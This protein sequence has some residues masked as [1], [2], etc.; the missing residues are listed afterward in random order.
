MQRII[1]FYATQVKL[2]WEWRGGPVALV[3][4]LVLVLVVAT[5]SFVI[6]AWL[7]PGMFVDSLSASVLAVILISLFNSLIRPVVLALI[8]P[9]SLILT[10]IAVLVLQVLAFLFAAWLLPGVHFTGTVAAL[11]A[12]FVYAIVNTV[13][14]A[15]LGVD[16]GGSYFGYLVQA[17]RRKGAAPPSDQPGVV[18]F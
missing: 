8:A 12:S 1:D 7:L 3:K 18:I 11:I 5:I 15:V 13:L 16:S 4:R 9:F 2:L 14:T 17:L 10:G 6:T